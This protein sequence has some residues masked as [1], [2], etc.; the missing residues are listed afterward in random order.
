[1][2]TPGGG[3]GG[4][5]PYLNMVGNFHSI[6]PRFLTFSDPIGSLFYAQLDLIDHLILQKNLFVSI[7]FSSRDNLS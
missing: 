4:A 2:P 7:I 3:G 1:M 6:D 5:L